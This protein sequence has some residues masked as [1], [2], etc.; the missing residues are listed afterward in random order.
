MDL[1]G[2][3]MN[4]K[5]LYALWGTMYILCAGLGFIPEPE[6]AL[7]VLLRIAA[8]LCFAPP[9]LLLWQGS[10]DGDRDTVKRVGILAASSLGATA[11]LIAGN[12][13]TPLAPEFWGS[14]LYGLLVVLSSPMVCCGNWAMSL[15]LWACL[16]MAAWKQLR[17]K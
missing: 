9:A 8:L 1:Q 5:T 3:F 4:K 6:G 7:A 15:F 11:V 10:K 17:G 12:F 13:L 2:A 14:V 16:L